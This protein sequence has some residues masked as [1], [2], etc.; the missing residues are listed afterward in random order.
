M[1]IVESSRQSIGGDSLRRLREN[2]HFTSTFAST[3]VPPSFTAPI[4]PSTP[5]PI[6]PPK[7]LLEESGMY[8][9]NRLL[10]S[11]VFFRYS[12]EDFEDFC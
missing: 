6:L 8:V 2:L 11:S 9:M 1:E 3:Q 10:Q 5:P 4:L 7:I 12:A